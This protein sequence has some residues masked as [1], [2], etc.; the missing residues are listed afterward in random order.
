MG[1]PD[2]KGKLIESVLGE[3]SPGE[4]EDIQ[5]HV[6]QC[7]ACGRE[8][9]NFQGAHDLL[10]AQLQDRDMP[11]HLVFLPEMARGMRSNFLAQLWRTAALAA[12]AAGVFLAIV[13][14]GYA[15]W[16]RPPLAAQSPQRAALTRGEI[17]AIVDQ[18]VR[19]QWAQ[20]KGE[21]A[22]SNEKLVAD[23]QRQQAQILAPLA[24]QLQ[25]LQ[26]TQSI[27]Y[28]ETQKQDALVDLMARNSVR[29]EGSPSTR[30]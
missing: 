24:A 8:L 16:G 14:T 11:A 9:S 28:Q 17:E 6:A 15:R 10:R 27:I 23:L 21:L 5:R 7:A 2:W 26:S 30:P 19:L 29:Q 18:Q 12:V 25:Y 4:E 13:L 20:Q 1:C 3:L 22:T